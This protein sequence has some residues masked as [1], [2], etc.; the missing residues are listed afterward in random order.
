MAGVPLR[1]V[2]TATNSAYFLRMSAEAVTASAAFAVSAARVFAVIVASVA[3]VSALLASSLL[4][5]PFAYPAVD[6]LCPAAAGVSGDLVA[7]LRI[8]CFVAAGT[9][10]RFLR[11]RCLEPMDV[12]RPVDHLDGRL[13]ERQRSPHAHLL[14]RLGRRRYP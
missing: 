2:S 3:G 10:Y 1:V 7:A 6:A 5:P 13:F 11:C 9:S 4:D 12:P 14:L 8:V